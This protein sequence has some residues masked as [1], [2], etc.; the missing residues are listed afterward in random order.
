MYSARKRDGGSA[1]GGT[2]RRSIAAA[3][4]PLR[5]SIANATRPLRRSISALVTRRRA[6]PAAQDP[7]GADNEAEEEEIEATAAEVIR[8]A[9]TFYN[10]HEVTRYNGGAIREERWYLGNFLGRAGDQP[11]IVVRNEDGAITEQKWFL[12]GL[13]GRANDQ[14]ALIFYYPDGTVSEQ[15][16]Y[17]DG[18]LGRAD[19]QPAAITYRPDGTIRSKEWYIDGRLGRANND[20]QP[21]FVTYAEDGTTVTKEER[22]WNN[23]DENNWEQYRSETWYSQGHLGRDDPS[24]PTVRTFCNE[25]L[26]SEEWYLGGGGEASRYVRY[27]FF[28]DGSVIGEEWFDQNGRRLPRPPQ[29][30]LAAMMPPLPPPPPPPPPRR[31][32]ARGVAYQV[33]NAFDALDH[34]RLA[35]LLDDGG[36]ASSSSSS[37]DPAEYLDAMIAESVPDSA[38]RAELIT[39]LNRQRVHLAYVTDRVTEHAALFFAALRYVRRQPPAF[40]RAYLKNFLADCTQ[41]YDHDDEFAAQSCTNGV[42]ERLVFA[43]GQ[44]ATLDGAQD[45]AA[46][47]VSPEQRAEYSAL[48]AML[49]PEERLKRPQLIERVRGLVNR[50]VNHDM[51]ARLEAAAGDAAA[52]RAMVRECVLDRVRAVTFAGVSAEDLD[53]VVNDELRVVDD[54]I[55]SG[56]GGRRQK[57]K[58]RQTRRR[59][60]AHRRL[61]SKMAVGRTRRRRRL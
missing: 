38:E 35:Q 42:W 20:D 18:Q 3:T 8:P 30:R 7:G 60:A 16:W 40:Q 13:R 5:R 44:A 33:H 51:V 29:D 61:L 41:A 28:A 23:G 15:G 14:P 46:A 11:A 21:V 9:R 43:L 34:N 25:R 10:R 55:V 52:Q 24:L 45:D 22:R 26:D 47:G 39:M 56:G 50:C 2:L 37:T 12:D 58:R 49:F 53:E 36:S 48:A 1:R 17:I 59:A 19:D 32:A 31:P 54:I 6:T 57:R 27:Y 4:R